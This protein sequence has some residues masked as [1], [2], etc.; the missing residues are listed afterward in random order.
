MNVIIE[1]RART[2]R[3]GGIKSYVIYLLKGLREHSNIHIDVVDGSR[4]S[5]VPLRS[6]LLLPYW[7][8]YQLETYIARNK[9]NVAHFTKAAIPR[10]KTAPTVVTIYDIIPILLPETQSLFRRAYWPTA[11]HHAAVQSDRI[12]TI[13]EKSKQ[14]IAKTFRVPEEKII[15]TTLAID[16]SHFKPMANYPSTDTAGK[17]ILFVG[18]WDERKNIKTLIRAFELIAG[19]IPHQLIVAGRP[20][21]K[22][23]GARVFAQKSKYADRIVFREHVPYA[24][25]PSLYSNADI[26]VWPSIYEGWGF[27]PQEAMACGTPVIVSNGGSLP[28]VVGD[29]GAIV[30]FSSNDLHE[31]MYDGDFTQRLSREMLNLIGNE[32]A[33]QRF[34]DA[35]VVQATKTTW[36]QITEKTVATYK[37]IGL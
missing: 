9:P 19:Q 34:C 10:K 7:M 29:A 33:K 2:A 1:A 36:A 23:D 25:L 14:D 3:S 6:E 37:E 12:I 22:D 24:D 18:T 30:P 21:H 31:R 27:P 5:P 11:L 17:Y 16:A 8:N 20:A 13:S 32:A 26:F 35:G 28:E 15:V 4:S